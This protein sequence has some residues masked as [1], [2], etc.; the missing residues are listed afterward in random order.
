ME[1]KS[2]VGNLQGAVSHLQGQV[3]NMLGTNYE[4]KLARNLDGIMGQRLRIRSLR[5]LKGS[6]MGNSG[7]YLD[8]MEAAEERGDITGQE[9]EEVN[10]TDFVLR[11][12]SPVDQSIVYLVVEA[13]VTAGDSDIN[14]A[15]DRAAILEK[16][17]GETTI[18]AVACNDFDA[19]RQQLALERNVTLITVGV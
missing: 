13:S 18:A 7:T 19:A 8:L 3:G 15:A 9:R 2:D 17:T 10:D 14:R 11:G 6:F 4:I 16:A 5:F 1:L 12:R